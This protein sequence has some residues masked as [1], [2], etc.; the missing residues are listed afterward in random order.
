MTAIPRRI[1]PGWLQQ[2]KTRLACTARTSHD[3]NPNPNYTALAAEI[4]SAEAEIARRSAFEAWVKAELGA[5]LN[6]YPLQTAA[7]TYDP[8]YVFFKKDADGKTV[9][10]TVERAWEKY[11]TALTL[12]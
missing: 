9:Y 1:N 2:Q 3:G 7:G 4:E 11:E 12:G 10:W 5:I 8:G 6:K